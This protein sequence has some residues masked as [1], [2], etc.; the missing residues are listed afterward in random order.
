[1]GIK[2]RIIGAADVKLSKETADKHES[3]PGATRY[4]THTHTYTHMAVMPRFE[5]ALGR[6]NIGG[7]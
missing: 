5:V 4:H 3:R 7:K 1:M 2:Y 6:F